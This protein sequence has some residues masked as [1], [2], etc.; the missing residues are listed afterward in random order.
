MAAGPVTWAVQA[1]RQVC[2]GG[3]AQVGDD[4]GGLDGILGVHGH[5]NRCGSSVLGDHRRHA[6]GTGQRARALLD[7]GQLLLGQG[8]VAAVEHDGG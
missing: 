2:L 7:E 3:R 5:D 4:V 8:V 1:L 6:G